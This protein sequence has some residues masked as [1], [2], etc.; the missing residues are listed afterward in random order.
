MFIALSYL[1]STVLFLYV[2][3]YLYINSILRAI[4]HF[5]NL[6]KTLIRGHTTLNRHGKKGNER[7]K[8]DRSTL[9][10]APGR[11]TNAPGST[12]PPH[13]AISLLPACRS[14]ILEASRAY[15]DRPNMKPIYQPIPLEM[16]I[17]A[18][19]PWNVHSMNHTYSC[20]FH[21]SIV[22]F[23]TVVPAVE[24]SCGQRPCKC[25]GPASFAL[26]QLKH[27]IWYPLG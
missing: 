11:P 1:Y 2:L 10:D 18:A 15:S 4:G 20:C 24:Y 25:F 14:L 19:I 26:W 27:K 8:Q 7:A 9:I 12:F 22:A 5:N 17:K 6:F 21:E 16:R 13:P 3:M 23:L